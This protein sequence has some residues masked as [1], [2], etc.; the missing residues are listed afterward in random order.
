M[1]AI[2]VVFLIV[3]VLAGIGWALSS[4]SAEAQTEGGP[5]E[6]EQEQSSLSVF[7]PK[8]QLPAGS[9]VSFPVDI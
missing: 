2:T 5:S 1:K 3:V 6:E 8:K 7:V 9:S 4:P